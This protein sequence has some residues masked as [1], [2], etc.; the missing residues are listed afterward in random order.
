M[1]KA[2][3]TLFVEGIPQPQGSTKSMPYK[4]KDGGI[5]IST[6]SSNPKM[7]PWRDKVERMMRDQQAESENKFN[8][9]DPVLMMCEFRFQVPKSKDKKKKGYP[10]Y[11]TSKPDLDKLTR[12]IGDAFSYAVGVDDSRIVK[13][14]ASKEYVRDYQKVGVNI[15]IIQLEQEYE[16]EG[17]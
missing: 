11:M 3:L 10:T 5:G 13:T 8:Q 12:A 15:Q 14:H 6:F 16:T 4:K 9:E 2:S 7:M 1:I 17:V